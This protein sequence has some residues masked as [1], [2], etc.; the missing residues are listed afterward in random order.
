MLS[1]RTSVR[2]LSPRG[3]W[4]RRLAAECAVRR[5]RLDLWDREFLGALMEQR[6][7]ATPCQLQ[8][9]NEI[10]LWCRERDCVS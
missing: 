7:R 8:A 3:E 9:L 1:G 4:W 5:D 2:S 10:A 6:Q